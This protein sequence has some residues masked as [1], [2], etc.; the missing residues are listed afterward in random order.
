[1]TTTE[2]YTTPDQDEVIASVLAHHERRASRGK[3]LATPSPAAGYNP[4][5][6]SVLFGRPS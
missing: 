2:L 5:S 6:L 1:V 4:D 3:A